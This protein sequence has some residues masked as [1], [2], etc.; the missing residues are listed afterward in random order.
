MW[1]QSG[2]EAAIREITLANKRCG[3]D[4]QHISDVGWSGLV[5]LKIASLING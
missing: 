4:I 2:D 5:L 1:S 3:I